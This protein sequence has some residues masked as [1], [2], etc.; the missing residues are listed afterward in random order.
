[1]QTKS[2][3]RPVCFMSRRVFSCAN[4]AG[5]LLGLVA[6]QALI[7]QA[8]FGAI[9]G[10]TEDTTGALIPNAKVTV[11]DVNKGTVQTVQSNGT[12][13]YAVGQLIPDTYSVK[14]EYAGFSPT[15]VSNIVVA[16][17]TTVQ[18]NLKLAITSAA[19]S[20]TVSAN[21]APSILQTASADVSEG[22]SSERLLTLP[23]LDRNFTSFTLLTP[24]VQRSS[25]N[26]QPTENPQGTTAINANGSNYGSFGWLLDG[27]DNREPIDGIVV[28]NPTIDSLSEMRV[29]TEDY[30]AEFG[31]AAGGFVIAE[32]RSGG[33][34]LH[35]D[36]FDFRRSG[37]LEARDPFTQFQ[38]DPVT[39]RYIPASL[40]DQFGGSVSGPIRKNKMFYFLDYQGTRQKTGSSLEENVPTATVRSACL[41]SGSTTCDLSQYTTAPLYDVANGNTYTGGQIPSSALSPQAINLLSL[42]PAP[43][44]GTGTVNN[45]I[46]S[47][48]GNNDGD[49]A[50][51]RLDDQ[52]TTDTHA[53]GRYDY[54]IFRLA[55]API[56][57]ASGGSGFGLGNTTGFD[58]VQN[59]SVASGFDEAINANL[60]TEV[61]FGFLDYHVAERKFD[62]SATPALAAGIANLNIPGVPD[63]NGAPTYDFSDSSIGDSSLG[64]GFG[65]QG[66]N[67][68]LLESEQVFQIANNWTKIVRNHT[69]RFG[70]DLRYALNLR[71]ASDNNRSGLLSF[72]PATTEL[73]SAPGSGLGLASFMLGEVAQFQRFD[74]YKETAAN[75]QKRGSFYAQDSWRTTH[76]LTLNYGLRWDIIFP[77]TVNAPGN[78]GFTYL[79]DGVIRVS[80]IGGIGTN[81]GAQL[82]LTDLGGRFGFAYQVRPNTVIRGGAAQMY[83][84]VGFFGTIFGSA[85]TQNLPVVTNESTGSTGAIDSPVYTFNSLPARPAQ[86][87]I[88]SDGLIPMMNGVSPNIRPNALILPRVDQFNVELQ[89][90]LGN[91]ASFTIGY[92]GNIAER[93][94]PSETE[95]FNINVPR[96]PSTPA[97]LTA[98]D[99]ATVCATGAPCSRNGR[100]PY[101]NRFN[102]SYN[103]GP[104]Q[105]C[106]QDLNY[107][108]PS[109][110]ANYN[111][112]QTKFENSLSNG[113][114]FIATYTWSRASNYGS[115]Y[116]A[117]EPRLEYGPEDTSRNQV[118][119]LNGSY[120]LP[121]GHNKMFLN[122]KNGVL[123]YLVGGWELAGT[124]TWESGLPFTPTYAECGSDQ[125]IDTN[126]AGPGTSSDCRPNKAG[127]SLALST[128]GFNPITHSRSYFTPV[129]PFGANGTVSG[130][131]SRP[132]FGTIGD[133]GRTSLRGPRDYFADASL[134][135]N[136]TVTERVK[137]Q[138]QF[139]AFNVF[140][141]VPLGLPS[142]SDARCIDC[143]AATTGEITSVDNAI[144]GSGQPYMRQLQFG[145]R[146]TF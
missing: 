56:F 41:N 94:Y 144:Y 72:S 98:T 127:G 110:R 43:N 145:A 15:V 141:H 125:D 42:L 75:R 134:F 58:Q 27:T 24:G 39:G 81:G 33:N 140:N 133:V 60:L 117:Q 28:V 119:V 112:L 3:R 128:G 68:P 21:S 6:S 4:I 104:T 36:A 131:F 14:A 49:Q 40:W 126:F 107:E 17:D 142:A 103:G 102:G 44:A 19:E 34:V 111:A 63:T 70:T 61:R 64:Q 120:E 20:V 55:G 143:T 122:S 130:A 51:I 65:N 18:L 13:N 106:N 97:D 93:I 12:G 146:F 25:F 123:D 116:F 53:F 7:A 22:I 73:S 9:S 85:M 80:G 89:Q 83:D 59:Q 87:T 76:K 79:P 77:E 84:D 5:I 45:Y 90:A 1:M 74:V 129:A 67:C 137:G 114:Q 78:G 105:C 88:P 47:G 124:T 99:P 132:D 92:V 139:Q 91:K 23:N 48:T 26:I 108:G 96:L 113:L 38:P 31:G 10:T 29:I 37:A 82:D 95:G 109:A 101:Y 35:G 138:L 57:G 115:T 66:C 135:K 50:D 118:F 69:I 100:R 2:G 8:V 16:A 11:T 54:S 62:A 136:F 46:G 86:P 30:A 71:N 32:T 121:F 52:V